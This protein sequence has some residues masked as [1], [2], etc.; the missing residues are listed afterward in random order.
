M[1]KQVIVVPHHPNWSRQFAQ[2]GQI[3]REELANNLVR[4]HHGGSTAIPGIHAKPIIDILA[5]VADLDRVDAQIPRLTTRGYEAMGE[6]G[7]PGRRYFR[8]HNAVGVRTHH[9]HVFS[10]GSAEVLRHLAFRDYMIAHPE[11]AQAYSQ[12]KQRLAVA[13]PDDIEAY[14]DG[15]DSFIKAM[16]QKSLEWIQLN[17]SDES[18]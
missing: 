5:E 13:Y 8:K 10:T 18:I 12:L 9:L 4:L 17:T 7:I 11:A 16:E 6:Y 2:E 3:L 15:K 1:I 14:M